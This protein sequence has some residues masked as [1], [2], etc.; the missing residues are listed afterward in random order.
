MSAVPIRTVDRI[1]WIE[2]QAISSI[3]PIDSPNAPV[4]EML[5]TDGTAFQIPGFAGEIQALIAL[6]ERSMEEL[7]GKL[8]KYPGGPRVQEDEAVIT[9]IGVA[10]N[11][12]G[13]RDE[14]LGREIMYAAVEAAHA[15]DGYERSWIQ[16]FWS[17]IGLYSA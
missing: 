12:L 15:K 17:G 5:M 13:K 14:V 8:G 3:R 2:R 9:A 4:C 10:L 6:R 16:K 7:I 1:E 11:K